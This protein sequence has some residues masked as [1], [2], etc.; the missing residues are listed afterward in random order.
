MKLALVSMPFLS[1][2]G[3]SPALAALSAHLHE[4]APDVRTTCH[5]AYLTLWE[6]LGRERYDALSGIGGAGE[7]LYAAALYPEKRESQRRTW[8]AALEERLRTAPRPESVLALGR[9]PEERRERFE[10]LLTHV[11]RH[12]GQ[13]ANEL[14]ESCDVVGFSVVADQVFA[15]VLLAREIKRLNAGVLTVLGGHLTAGEMG[16][17]LMRV[18][19]CIDYVIQGEGEEPLEALLRR[20]DGNGSEE[21]L[22]A[23][24][25]RRNLDAH[26]MGCPPFEVA[27][28]SLLPVPDLTHYEGFARAHGIQW[29]L[30]VEGAR[31]CWWDRTRATGDCTLRCL[32]CR[33]AQ[34]VTYR[35][36]PAG[37]VAREVALLVERHQTPRVNFLDSSM[38]NS[39]ATTFA[40]AL[41]PGV[42]YNCAL[43]ANIRPREILALWEAG[44]ENAHCGVEGLSTSYLA[45]LHK[46]TTAIQNLQLMRTCHELGL[47][48]TTSWLL[49]FPGSTEAEVAETV[50]VIERFA[51]AYPPPQFAHEF[52]LERESPIF[53]VREEH[54]IRNVRSSDRLRNV[55]PEDVWSRLALVDISWDYDE[56]GQPADWTPVREAVHRWAALYDELE[57][58]ALVYADVGWFLEISDRRHENFRFVTL[59]RVAREL[60][61]YCMEIRTLAEIEQRFGGRSNR[62]Q[63]TR[64]LDQL[65]EWG[66]TFRE[67]NQFLSLAVASSPHIA[68]RRYAETL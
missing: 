67:G 6:A 31:G 9:S 27:D 16:A 7:V 26:P 23:T 60:Y 3:P 39:G 47:A 10:D 49:D 28:V 19:D 57:D 42:Q 21:E 1:A 25:T 58:R 41:P 63:L 46:G 38:R 52:D 53:L 54:G 51:R 65:V 20:L 35:T 48:L 34:S 37:R 66:F 55:L 30:P 11:A 44:L 68:A 8:E 24:L 64:I 13:L 2:Y 17:S 5:P 22:P 40:A 56:R 14:A 15:S 45:R 62:T 33:F 50:S 4:H 59:E 29:W 36:K 12:A 61:L 18:Y 43:R 32:F